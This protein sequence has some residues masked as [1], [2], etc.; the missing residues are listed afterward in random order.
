[1]PTPAERA[2]ADVQ[3]RGNRHE[4]GY[5]NH[6]VRARGRFLA[7]HPLCVMCQARG[8]LTPANVVDH[9]VPHR[10]DQVLFWDTANWQSLCTPCHNGPKRLLEQAAERRAR[11]NSGDHTKPR[12]TLAQTR[13]GSGSHG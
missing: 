4:Q 10:G 3:R 5:D 11:A 6:W 12:K 2:R 9:I 1:M 8:R 13:A 7:A